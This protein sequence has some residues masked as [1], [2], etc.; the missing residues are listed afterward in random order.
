[1][2]DE[3]PPAPITAGEAP[4]SPRLPARS[5]KRG[6]SCSS[7]HTMA[8]GRGNGGLSDSSDAAFVAIAVLMT[9]C[10]RCCRARRLG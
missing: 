6:N 7:L 4:Q 10:W 2:A 3:K 5:R 9:R 1:M 8:Q